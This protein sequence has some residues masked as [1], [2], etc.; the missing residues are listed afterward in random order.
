M[1]EKRIILRYLVPTK[2]YFSTSLIALISL[3]V[4]TTVVWLTLL[5]LS[6]TSGIETMWLEKLTSVHAPMRIVPKERYHQEMAAKETY[7]F[8]FTTL[9]EQMQSATGQWEHAGERNLAKAL[10]SSLQEAQNQIPFPYEEYECAPSLM[11]LTLE[12]GGKKMRLSQMAYLLSF[13]KEN[14]QLPQLLL[15]PSSSD[16]L[17]LQRRLQ[18]Q[19]EHRRFWSHISLESA[20]LRVRPLTSI[21]DLPSGTFFCSEEEGNLFLVPE[22]REHT[23]LLS[24]SQEQAFLLVGD[25]SYPLEQERSVY[26]PTAGWRA[27]SGACFAAEEVG[28]E[29]V[30]CNLEGT[31]CGKTLTTSVPFSHLLS[32]DLRATTHF[33]TPPSIQPLWAYAVDN[34]W[35]LPEGSEQA[36]LL[37]KNYQKSGARLGDRGHFA[38][39]ASAL[40]ATQEMRIGF[41]VA[42]F[43]AP[44]MIPTGN[45]CIYTSREITQTL[46][47]TSKSVCLDQETQNGIFLWPTFREIEP[48][49]RHL[50]SS[51]EKEGLG[52]YFRLETFRDYPFAQELMAQFQSDRTL[53]L[54]V[55]LIMIFVACSNIVSMMVVIVKEKRR[56]NDNM[57]S[58]GASAKSILVIFGSIGLLL[59]MVGSLLGSL[60]AIWTLEHL[61]QLVAFLSWMQGHAAFQ[62][63][64]FGTSLPNALSYQA[65]CFVL[66]TTPICSLIA[67]LIPAYTASK[68]NLTKTLRS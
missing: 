18:T 14:P 2:K 6:V 20:S 15:A 34:Q 24:L 13:A 32:P 8:G 50:E 47:D 23:A 68:I 26:L 36:I 11:S 10:E 49:K 43:Y 54:L 66:I 57:V 42:G 27:K 30:F 25:Q 29:N 22:K 55:A 44:G 9:Q 62:E 46:L 40:S 19:E 51:L 1:F 3:F 17:H 7:A 5:F 52:I 60:L 37:P 56:E 59:G 65:L 31:F 41:R 35:H 45:R 4:I 48:V 16:L 67:G 33:S 12:S 21:Q 63:A 61:S 53:F 38:F 28:R 58:L 39:L 64:F